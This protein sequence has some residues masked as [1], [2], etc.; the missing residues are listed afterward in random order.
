VTVDV[1]RGAPTLQPS[2]RARVPRQH[3][4]GS[5]S[6]RTSGK[7]PPPAPVRPVDPARPGSSHR[8]SLAM[9]DEL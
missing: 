9:P 5:E 3:R 4:S 8:E 1:V 2:A 6:P 7:S